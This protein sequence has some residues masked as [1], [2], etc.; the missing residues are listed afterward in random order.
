MAID[1]DGR[2][3]GSVSGGCVEAAVVAE[4]QDVLRDG[5]P[6]LLSYGVTD[7]AAWDVGLTCGGRIEIFVEPAARPAG[8]PSHAGSL[9][10]DLGRL[11]DGAPAVRAVIIRGPGAMLGRAAIFTTGDAPRGDIPNSILERLTR[12]VRS[13]MTSHAAES[14]I[15]PWEGGEVEVLLDPLGPP[16][17]LVIVGAVHI[18]IALARLAK[19]VGFH[20][21]VVDPRRSFATADRFPGVDALI[22]LWPDQGLRQA[23]L[24][25]GTAVAVL[26][27]DPKL[28]DPALLVA[29]RSP[30]AYVGALGS[31]TTHAQRRER[32]LAAGLTEAELARLHAPIGN[33]HG[34]RTPEEIAVSILAE[35]VGSGLL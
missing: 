14:E 30:A 4:A 2:M 31:K 6:R 3:A 23:G 24:T 29:L 34:G 10:D 32:L 18:A 8:P 5:T 16:P 1:E 7:E 11:A 35:I 20:V 28:D 9:V 19:D 33:G 17:A 13:L 15:V 12:R 27:H 22:H 21:T 25:P 26:S